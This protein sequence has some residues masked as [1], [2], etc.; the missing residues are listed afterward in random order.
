VVFL[1]TFRGS[2]NKP[3]YDSLVCEENKVA[4][5]QKE[6]IKIGLDKFYNWKTSIAQ[7]Y[8]QYQVEMIIY[9]NPANF[10]NLTFWNLKNRNRKWANPEKKTD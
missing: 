5:T 7:D 4:Y 10:K 2:L 1:N 8:P 9:Q 3:F 6:N